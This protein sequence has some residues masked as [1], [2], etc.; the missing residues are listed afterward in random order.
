[1]AILVYESEVLQ[2]N[3]PIATLQAGVGTISAL[4]P[5]DTADIDVY[6]SVYTDVLAVTNFPTADIDWHYRIVWGLVINE[7]ENDLSL[8]KT[9]AGSP[10]SY[11]F[12][13]VSYGLSDG[14]S[15]D[16][17][18]NYTNQ[19]FPLAAFTI[20]AVFA[21]RSATVPVV[22]PPPLPGKV[23][24]VTSS[25]LSVCVAD[26]CKV[27]GFGNL[28]FRYAINYTIQLVIRNNLPSPPILG[29]GIL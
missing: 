28:S 10:P 2:N 4:L 16:F 5:V 12:G 24:V 23:D 17:L 14:I 6:N 11:N 19:V 27:F 29:L 15:A 22:Q 20:S 25:P 1:M 13:R 9:F 7:F 8:R 3:P 21:R 18:W 26:T